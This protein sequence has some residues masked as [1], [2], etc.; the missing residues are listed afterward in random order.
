MAYSYVVYTGNGAT[1]QYAIPFQYIKKEHV[2]VFVNFVD[3]AYTYVNNT[4][5]LLASAPANGIRVEVRRITPASTPLVDFV[6]GSTLVASDL[7]TS[8]LQHLFLEQELD[9]FTK[10]TI[11]IDPATG[12]PTV[13]NQRITVLAAPVAATDAAN[14]SYVDTNDAL[15]L[16]KA[17]DSMTGAL[18]MG[19]NKITGLGDPTNAQDA[20]TKSYVD[21]GATNA[22]A[23]AAA[24]ASSATNSANSATASANSATA[25]ANSATAAANSATAAGTSES[26]AATSEANASTSATNSANSATAAANSAASALAAF[27]QFDD[28]YLGSFA[29]DPTLDNDGDPLTA[30]DLYFSTTLSAMRVYTGA[31]WVTAYV[32]GDAANIIFTPFGTIAATDVQA[33]I[34]EVFTEAT[35]ANAANVAFTPYGGVASG[36]VQDAIE[37]V[38]DDV[39]AALPK[40]GGTMTGAIAMGTNKITGM[41]DPTVAQDAATKNYVDTQLSGISSNSIGQGNSSVGVGDSGVGIIII[42]ADGYPIADFQDYEINFYRPQNQRSSLSLTNQNQLKFLEATANG[43]NSVGFKGPASIAADLTWTLPAAD[44]TAN[45]ALATNGSATLSWVSYLLSSGGTVTGDVLLDNQSD[46]RFGEA[47]GQGGHYVAFQAPSA[48]AANVTWTLPATDAT[49]SGH[50]LKSNAAGVLS[51]GTAGGA[52]GGGGDDVFYE[53]AQTVTTNYTLTAG[54]NAMS[55]GPITISNGA[56]VTV[57]SGQ[58]WVIV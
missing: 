8:N 1:T 25:A 47:T 17:G 15:K 11:S 52:T 5:V 14:K 45:Q 51:W 34:E 58:S 39:N 28:R 42:I 2:K 26:N 4:T 49:V 54:K 9:D 31:V 30:G 6:D 57:G 55:A 46:L 37:E 43:V 19:T 41:G 13:N 50:A 29:A 12:L 56:T 38:I 21:T 27:D 3:T 53:N 48:I 35:S 24:S 22:A 36:N 10:Q 7:D 40:A 18:A 33:A 23:S 20:A 16:N 44:G 32:P